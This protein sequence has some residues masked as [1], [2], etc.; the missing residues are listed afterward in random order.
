[1][2]N[3]VPWLSVLWLVPL[4]GAVLIILLPP[5]RRRLAKWAGMVVSVL[6]LAVSIVVAAEFKPS[7]EP[8]QFVEKHSW[9]PAFG[10]GY[11]LGVDGI[12]VVLVLLTTV[13]IPLL[14]VA[15]WNDATDADDLS[16]QAGGTPSARLRRA[17]D[18]QVANAPEA[19]T[20][21]WH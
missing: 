20:P 11:T 2:V 13:L 4:A 17:C 16:P 3:N 5:G 8:Y 1:M 10:A 15:G 12:A 6:T 9:I 19:C 7:A 14:L 18:R 21:T